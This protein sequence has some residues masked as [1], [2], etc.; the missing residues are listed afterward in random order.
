MSERVFEIHSDLIRSLGVVIRKYNLLIEEM[1][2]EPG[3]SVWEQ[4]CKEM[5]KNPQFPQDPQ[6]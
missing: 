1:E 4:L 3:Y 5:D 2:V 6:S